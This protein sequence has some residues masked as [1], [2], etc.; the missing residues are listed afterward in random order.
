[1]KQYLVLVNARPGW[2]EIVRSF[3]FTHALLPDESA[4][5][6]SLEQAGWVPLY[7]DHVATLLE[8]R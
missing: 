3:G 2:Q 5:K 8:A 1:M 7:K 4:L 6:A